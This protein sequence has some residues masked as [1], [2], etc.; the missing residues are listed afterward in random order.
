MPLTD[1][2]LYQCRAAL[3]FWQAVAKRSQVHPLE[4]PVG[5]KCYPSDGEHKPLAESEIEDLLAMDAAWVSS[6]ATRGLPASAMVTIKPEATRLRAWLQRNGRQP[7]CHIDRVALYDIND[8]EEGLDAL[9]I[10][11]REFEK[12]YKW[13]ADSNDSE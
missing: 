9:S 2:Q 8:L 13:P 5:R 6:P 7:V 10:K 1:R 3:A 11:D 4:H 12:R